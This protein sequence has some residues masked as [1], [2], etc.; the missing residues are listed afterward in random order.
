MRVATLY[1][2]D[3]PPQ[4]YSPT[5]GS[6]TRIFYISWVKISASILRLK[7][8][9]PSIRCESFHLRILEVIRHAFHETLTCCSLE[10]AGL[11][12]YGYIRRRYGHVTGTLALVVPIRV[13]HAA[14][15]MEALATLFTAPI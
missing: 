10:L 5:N 3:S 11:L 13:M 12:C 9:F 8:A 6:P 4:L 15:T 14:Y 2:N 1:L 7:L